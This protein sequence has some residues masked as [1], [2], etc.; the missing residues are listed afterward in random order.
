M[1]F[2]RI[3]FTAVS[4]FVAV[5]AHALEIAPYTPAALAQA[6]QAD[7]AYA[8]HFYADWCPVCRAQAKALAAMKADPKLDVTVFV[9]NYDTEKGLRKQYGVHTQSTII[10]FKGRRETARLAGDTDPARIRAVLA[11]PL[12][13]AS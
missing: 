12:Q 5:S 13:P 4:F 8:L 1:N 9:V 10:A 11:S 3:V 2:L 7:A 6:Q